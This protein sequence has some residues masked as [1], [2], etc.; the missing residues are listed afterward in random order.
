M[1]YGSGW[2]HF[3]KAILAGSRNDKKLMIAVSMESAENH[4]IKYDY[5]TKLFT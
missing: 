1:E 5:M 3:A 4:E 2:E